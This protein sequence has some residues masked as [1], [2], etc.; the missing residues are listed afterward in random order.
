M[1]KLLFAILAFPMLAMGQTPI[2]ACGSLSS[3]NTTYVLQNNVTASSNCFIFEAGGITLNLNGYTVTYD[4]TAQGSAVYGIMADWNKQGFHITNGTLVQ[5]TGNDYQSHAIDMTRTNG[6]CVEVDHITFNYQG[7]D[8]EAY[9][10]YGSGTCTSPGIYI[11]DNFMYPNG[12]KQTL[13]HYGNFGAI[14]I[15]AD[16]G[17]I[18]IYNNTISGKGY[19][20]MFIQPEGASSISITYNNISMAAPVEDGYAIDVITPSTTVNM[21]TVIAHNTINQSSGRGIA[22]EGN[23][24]NS[25]NA[26]VYN[27]T[28]TVKEACDSGEYGCPGHPI[29]I[30]VRFGASSVGVYDNTVTTYSGTSACPPQFASQ[31]GSS[32]QGYGI[33]VDNGSNNEVHN[34]NVIAIAADTSYVAAGFYVNGQAG[35][36][37]L[38]DH[39]NVTSNSVYIDL[40]D[41]DGYGTNTTF[42]SNAFTEGASPQDFTSIRMGYC[43]GWSP[44]GNILLDN[45]WGGASPD[46]FMYANSGGGTYS[47]S[48][49]YYLTVTVQDSRSNPLSGATVTAVGQSSL[50]T[51]TGTTNSSGVAVLALTDYTHSGNLGPP[52]TDVYTYY[53][54]HT[55]TAS[56]TVYTNATANVTMTSDQSITMQ[57]GGFPISLN[58]VA[59]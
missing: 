43:C 15:T 7:N 49:K 41:E 20:G 54:P 59:H 21:N 45:T 22:I 13:T 32:C 14:A 1:K 26:S 24:T 44:T 40:N 33:K 36:N 8:N 55:V 12:T 58:T 27:N 9:V 51:V 31:T 3:A 52:G 4:N 29:G 38:F 11:H 25:Y 23:S 48:L 16:T 47:I 2:T 46:N 35:T 19:Q 37:I 42:A 34:N 39:N 53:T 18:N 10:S 50:E 30:I 28:V 56:M 17:I 5:G 6:G 57:L